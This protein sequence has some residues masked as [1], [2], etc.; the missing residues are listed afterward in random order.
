MDFV[1]RTR[2]A[3]PG[4]MSQGGRLGCLQC[5]FNGQQA[6]PLTGAGLAFKT[7][8]IM[9]GLAHHLISAA[10]PEY[11][12]AGVHIFRQRFCPAGSLDP[13]QIKTGIFGTGQNDS[14]K[15][16]KG[17]NFFKEIYTQPIQSQQ[18]IKIRKVRNMG[19][20]YDRNRRVLAVFNVDLFGTFDD[21]GIFGLNL[22]MRIPGENAENR[23][24]CFLLDPADAVFK[25][26]NIAPETIDDKSC[27]LSTKILLQAFQRTDD[28]RK[29]PTTV[30]VGHQQD[31]RIC[32]GCHP[33][34]DNIVRHEVYLRAGAGAFQNNQF[35]FLT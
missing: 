34:I 12:T 32:M 1:P 28:L 22:D 8:G 14:L 9:H 23:F 31:R 33:E 29:H 10:N 13:L 17:L 5:G 4:K 26:L 15:G 30:D 11:M 19:Q 3:I 6:H 18:R 25:E 7:G 35:V 16:G 2:P 20:A 24:P 27:N 21:D